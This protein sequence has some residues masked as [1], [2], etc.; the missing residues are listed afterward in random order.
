MMENDLILAQFIN[1]GI[2]IIVMYF[3]WIP[4]VIYY[5]LIHKFKAFIHNQKNKS[6][7][8]NANIYKLTKCTHIYI[9]NKEIFSQSIV[10]LNV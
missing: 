6:K 10:A 8:F 2:L 1:V 3:L 9:Y 7:Y 4:V 5:I